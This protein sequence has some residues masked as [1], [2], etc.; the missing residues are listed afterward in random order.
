MSI[1]LCF[2]DQEFDDVPRFAF[3]YILNASSSNCK[4]QLQV[5][6]ETFILFILEKHSIFQFEQ[7]FKIALFP[8][9]N[10]QV[11]SFLR[12]CEGH[13]P[14]HVAHGDVCPHSDEPV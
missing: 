10:E 1:V 5:I 14:V 3:F 13:F 11:P 6:Y 4:G 9:A 2:N 8:Q 12:R 7:I